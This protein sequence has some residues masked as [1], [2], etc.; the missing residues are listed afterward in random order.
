MIGA[1][2][3]R[4]AP[5]HGLGALIS[6]DTPSTPVILVKLTPGQNDN[7]PLEGLLLTK[8][9]DLHQWVESLPLSW[10]CLYS[11]L[12]VLPAVAID[13]EWALALYLCNYM[14]NPGIF[15]PQNQE[16]I[17]SKDSVNCLDLPNLKTAISFP[18]FT[19]RKKSCPEW[20]QH[21]ASRMG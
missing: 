12:H 1:E 15:F 7:L 14:I 5:P 11:G 20:C 6:S 3:A 4:R 10:Q 2:D 8:D 17:L 19:P 13:N 9:T 16:R 21:H 18:I